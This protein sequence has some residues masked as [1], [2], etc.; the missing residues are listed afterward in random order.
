MLHTARSGALVENQHTRELIS[1]QKMSQKHSNK[2][3]I[4]CTSGTQYLLACQVTQVF[5]VVFV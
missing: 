4:E 2:D 5:V 1:A 3:L